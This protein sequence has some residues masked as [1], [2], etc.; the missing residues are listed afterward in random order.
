MEANSPIQATL[1]ATQVLPIP[2]E[3]EVQDNQWD[4]EHV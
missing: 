1:L 4:E 2:L 3:E